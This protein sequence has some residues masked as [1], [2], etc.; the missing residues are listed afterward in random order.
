M[1]DHVLLKIDNLMDE[2]IELLH[3]Y[4]VL[5]V[6]VTCPLEELRRREEKRGNPSGAGES[7]LPLLIPQNTYDIAVDTTKE[8]CVDKIIEILGYPEKFIAFETLWQQRNS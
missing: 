1:I 6:H 5:F 8:E 4:P 3:E 2:C 7:Q